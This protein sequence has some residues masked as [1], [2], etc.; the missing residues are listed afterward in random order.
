MRIKAFFSEGEYKSLYPPSKSLSPSGKNG[1]GGGV[2]LKRPNTPQ[3]QS[4]S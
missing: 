4:Y 3:K 2:A 1:G